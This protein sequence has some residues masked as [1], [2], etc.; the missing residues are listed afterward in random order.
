MTRVAV[1]TDYSY[2]RDGEGVYAERAFSLFLSR[3]A[4]DVDDMVLVG[5]LNPKPGESHYRLAD[6]IRFVSLPHYES[7]KKPLRTLG[8]MARSLRTFA[9]ALGSVDV[10][11]LLGPHL[12]GIAFALVAKA[13]GTPVVLG[14]RQ[15][16][17]EMTRHRHPDNALMNLAARVLERTWRW[18]GRA[19]P[20]AVVGDEMAEAYRR[21]GGRVLSMN[22]SLIR[23]SDV[24]DPAVPL[25]R[26][27]EG[28]RVILAVG[29]LEPEKNPVLLADVLH[30]LLEADPRYR[31]RVCGDGP[32][33]DELE[34]AFERLGVSHRAEIV[35]YVPL[36][37]G[38]LDLYRTSHVLLH[39]SNTEGLPQVLIEA[40]SQGLPVVAT[41]VGGIPAA[42]SSQALLVPPRDPQEAAAAVA[43]VCDD[44]ELRERL[45]RRGLAYAAEHTIENEISRVAELLEST[46]R[47]R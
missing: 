9:A 24:P 30:R 33:R 28:D 47:S 20:V 46:A 10:V 19:R 39:P 11:W 16:L 27:Y 37:G 8:P 42:L 31:L 45:V 15:N 41:A 38:L 40:L 23:T 5:R 2:W 29:R 25:A 22:V 3:L 13:S 1:Y 17:P 43:R 44:A 21:D 6:G 7:L 14:V 35:G 4:D 34:A 36:D 26:P 32:M 18:L 12:L